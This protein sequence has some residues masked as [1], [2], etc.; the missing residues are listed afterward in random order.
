MEGVGCE[1]LHHLERFGTCLGLKIIFVYKLFETFI[2][3][4]KKI[5]FMF[6]NFWFFWKKIMLFLEIS[7]LLLEFIFQILETKIRKNK[8]RNFT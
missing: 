2:S 8:F 3:I 5:Y 1:L 6:G 4:L 7:I